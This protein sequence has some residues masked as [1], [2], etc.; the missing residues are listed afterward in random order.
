MSNPHFNPMNQLRGSDL[1]DG[2]EPEDRPERRHIASPFQQ[3]DVGPSIAAIEAQSFLRDTP[4]V[5]DLL[6]DPAEHPLRSSFE[7]VVT[8][9]LILH[10]RFSAKVHQGCSA[11]MHHEFTAKVHHSNG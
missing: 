6:Q 7:V 8:L 2:G 9:C 4:L 1:Q 11:K 5:T 10:H 3:A